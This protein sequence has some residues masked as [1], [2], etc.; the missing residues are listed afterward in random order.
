MSI[1]GKTSDSITGQVLKPDDLVTVQ[2]GS[3]VSKTLVDRR[4]GP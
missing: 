4:R 3:V 2:E 1:A